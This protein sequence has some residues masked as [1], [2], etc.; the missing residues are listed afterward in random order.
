MY[1]GRINWKKTKKVRKQ[2]VIKYND[3]R[4][5]NI[6]ELYKNVEKNWKTNF[7]KINES[8]LSSIKEDIEELEELKKKSKGNKKTNIS[9]EIV[10]L[11]KYKKKLKKKI[12][13]L[14]DTYQI[15]RWN[16]INRKNENIKDH[17]ICV[18]DLAVKI[19]S[20]IDESVDEKLLIESALFHDVSKLFIKEHRHSDLSAE[21]YSEFA[22]ELNDSQ[23]SMVYYAISM[24]NR[25]DKMHLNN[26]REESHLLATIIHDA[27]KISKIYKKSFWILNKK[28]YIGPN[29]LEKRKNKLR[30]SLI[31][32]ESEEILYN[33]IKELCS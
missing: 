10:E 13:N 30:K 6:E 3:L 8:N 27:D 21:F 7:I 24:H 11:K 19:N 28:Q 9:E 2:I 22:S 26:K 18:L 23:K 25:R 20:V 12:N 33:R 16:R 17:S 32:I 14:D 1:S 15:F 4:F 31:M 29:E 5:N